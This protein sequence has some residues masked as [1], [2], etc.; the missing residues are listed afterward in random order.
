MDLAVILPLAVVLFVQA[1][2]SVLLLCPRAVARHV[3]RLLAIT[4]TSA[5]VQAVVYTLVAAVSATTIASLIQLAGIANSMR[6]QQFADRYQPHG[7]KG[8]S[9]SLDA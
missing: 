3:A 4:R 2:L 8:V 7:Q 6:A 5:V 1:L 9:I